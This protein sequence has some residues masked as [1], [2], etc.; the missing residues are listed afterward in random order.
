MERL[1]GSRPSFTNDPRPTLQTAPH[2]PRGAPYEEFGE[3]QNVLK[4]PSAL[5]LAIRRSNEV[6]AQAMA[7]MPTGAPVKKGSS[8]RVVDATTPT[9]AP[10]RIVSVSP[11]SYSGV[12]TLARNKKRA[13]HRAKQREARRAKKT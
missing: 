13:A 5:A 6:H 1:L 8:T 10:V 11:G 2:S 7:E 12:G 4:A 3:S 9:R